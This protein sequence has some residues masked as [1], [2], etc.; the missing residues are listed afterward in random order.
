MNRRNW[1]KSAGVAGLGMV[2]A[3]S[4]FRRAAAADA[5]KRNILFF[6]KSAGFEHSVIKT[7]DAKTGEEKMGHAHKVLAELGAKN[8]FEITHTKDG[9]VFTPENIAKYD[10]FFFYTT[11]DLTTAGGDKNPPMTP[12]GKA[13]LL[14]AIKN[15]K[16]FLGSHSAT[17]TFHTSTADA[18]RYKN[19]G[20]KADPYIAMIGAEFIHHGAQQSAKMVCADNKFPGMGELKDGIELM[21]EWYSLK[22]FASNLHVLLVQETTGM[23]GALYERAPYPATWAR[24]HGK[25]RVFYTSMGH[26]EDVW[27]NPTFQTILTGALNWATGNVEADV[28]PNIQTVTPHCLELPKPEPPKKK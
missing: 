18:D 23:K 25:G 13:A 4:P 27:T 5:P 16:G 3:G 14:E 17:D 26:R 15:G 20:D 11:G 12:E 6:T 28:T 19:F 9:S 1:L 24:A 10:A 8:N 7:K 2:L 21:D 22:E